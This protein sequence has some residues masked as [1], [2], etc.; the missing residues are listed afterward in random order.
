MNE[1]CQKAFLV[2][3]NDNLTSVKMFAKKATAVRSENKYMISSLLCTVNE[4]KSNCFILVILK[5]ACWTLLNFINEFQTHQTYYF[6]IVHLLIDTIL[7]L[8]NI[9]KEDVV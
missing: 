6:R 1:N 9:K 5:S 8:I 3:T 2:Q 4:C 7:K